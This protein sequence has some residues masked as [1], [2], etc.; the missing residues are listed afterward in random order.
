MA[1]FI[2]DKADYF[3][4]FLTAEEYER[5]SK[6][7]GGDLEISALSNMFQCPIQYV[8]SRQGH[9]FEEFVIMNPNASLL[10]WWRKLPSA[11]RRQRDSLKSFER[12][13]EVWKDWIRLKK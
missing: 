10:G 5:K 2:E 7:W 3:K 13:V 6:R 1:A 8:T 11:G 12:S 4:Q 9:E